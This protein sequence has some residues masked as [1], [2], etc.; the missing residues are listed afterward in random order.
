MC[1]IDVEDGC[2]IEL[3]ID[4]I[5]LDKVICII[6]F[7]FSCFIFWVVWI[8]IF[9]VRRRVWVNCRKFEIFFMFVNVLCFFNLDVI[10]FDFKLCFKRSGWNV[11]IEYL[12]V[13]G[14]V[15]DIFVGF[16]NWFVF[17]CWD[18]IWNKIVLY[19]LL[20]VKWL[21]NI[22]FWLFKFSDGSVDMM[23]FVWILDF[24]WVYEVISD[25]RKR[26]RGGFCDL[27]EFI[28]FSCRL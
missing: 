25:G 1:F 9:V 14:L 4:I 8:F 23:V 26:W 11:I 2:E 20:D 16:E 10:I 22:L 5:F 18:I 13:D 21:F 15:W 7:V 17:I 3:I 24:L 28:K 12:N 19:V 27:M 6:E